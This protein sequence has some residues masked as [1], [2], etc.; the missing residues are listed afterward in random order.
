MASQQHSKLRRIFNLVSESEPANE[1]SEESAN[2]DL[3]D[4]HQ[5]MN[6][7]KQETTP[8][9]G[10][11]QSSRAS[12]IRWSSDLSKRLPSWPAPPGMD[13]GIASAVKAFGDNFNKTWK[14]ARAPPERGTVFFSGMVE[15]IGS[16]GVAIV[17]VSGAYHAAE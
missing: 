6:S 17:D 15:L 1:T 12:T 7:K 5:Q 9:S 14:P 3:K 4:M 11:E 16:K 8:E 10:E 13:D 2:L